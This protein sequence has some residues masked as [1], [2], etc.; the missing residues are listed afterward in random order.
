LEINA[1]NDAVLHHFLEMLDKHLLAYI[2][3]QPAELASALG[4]IG[5]VI[6]NKWL[7]LAPKDG[8]HCLKPTFEN[9][10]GHV[11][12]Q[13]LDTYTKVGTGLQVCA[14]LAGRNDDVDGHG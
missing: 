8:Q 1:T 6:E 3:D 10:L 4:A 12:L 7:P 13:N 14:A 11:P 2:R 9:R 5:Q